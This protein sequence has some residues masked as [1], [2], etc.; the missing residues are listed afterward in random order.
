MWYFGEERGYF[1]PLSE[2]LPEL[3]VKR[4]RLI[5]LTRESQKHPS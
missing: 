4:F 3:K 2:D 5:A 1:L